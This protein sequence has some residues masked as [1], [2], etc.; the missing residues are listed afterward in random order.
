[1]KTFTF[2]SYKG[3]TGR[4]LLLANIAHYLARL[5]KRVV[6]V[7]F[8]FE[9]PGLH[10]KLNINP[11][12]VPERGAVDYLLATAQGEGPPKNLLDYLVQVPLPEGTK[13]SL[14]LMPAGSAPTGEYWKGLTALLRQDLFT[15]PEGSGLAAVLELKARIEEELQAEFLLIDSRTGVTELAGVTTTVLADKVVCLMLANLESQMGAR[16]VLRS[17]RHAPRLAGQGPIEVIP[18]LSRVPKRDEETVRETLSFLN[19]PG[20]TSDDTLTLERVFVLRTDPEL[21]WGEK[22]H[23]GNGESQIRSPLYQDYLTLIPE[24]VETDPALVKLRGSPDFDQKYTADA[25]RL[26]GLQVN[27]APDEDLDFVGLLPAYSSMERAKADLAL[28][29]ARL[30]DIK[31]VNHDDKPT[32]ILRLWLDLDG[33][34]GPPLEIKEEDLTGSRRIEARSHRRF[35]LRFT[36]LFKGAPPEDWRQRV[37]LCVNA[38]GFDQ[39]RIF[40][41]LPWL[42]QTKPRS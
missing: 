32:E 40:S 29:M 14:H 10:Y 17:L 39:L 11:A 3:G 19:A 24:L 21:A 27:V 18:V 22:L 31:I 9:A 38:T 15:N 37:V 34:P 26:S 8:D 20:P 4:S 13:G 41:D 28:L 16:A 30:S 36:A 35:A 33:H 6:A 7:D 23:L 5:G 2:Y 42:R 12:A 1:M 25:G